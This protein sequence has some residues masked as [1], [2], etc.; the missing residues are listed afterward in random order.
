MHSNSPKTILGIDP[1]FERL[2][3]AILERNNG[4]EKLL[5]SDC[6]TTSRDQ[7]TPE[8]IFE[9]GSKIEAIINEYGPEVLAIEKLFF[10]K[11]QKTA[12]DVSE[13]RGV[14][15]YEARK[16]GLQICQYTPLEIKVATTGYG[17]ADKKQVIDMVRKLIKMP[18]KKKRFDD[19]FDAIAV[20][21]TC[22]ARERF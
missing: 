18:E 7:E 6:L 19:E 10:N 15:I 1:G 22:S 5:H 13:L 11:N 2:G 12:M 9:L 3:I 21:I 17:K 14:I 20:A 16:K 4:K 8:R